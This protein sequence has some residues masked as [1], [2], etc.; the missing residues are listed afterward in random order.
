MIRRSAKAAPRLL[1]ISALALLAPAAQAAA[2]T[3]PAI[4]E[5]WTV[6]RAVASATG[7]ARPLAGATPVGTFTVKLTVTDAAG[8]HAMIRDVITVDP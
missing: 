4:E 7:G 8:L 1:A 5:S 3:P 6:R 2:A